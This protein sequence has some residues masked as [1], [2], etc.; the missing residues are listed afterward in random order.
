[1]ESKEQDLIIVGATG[2][3]GDKVCLQIAKYPPVTDL[4]WTIAGRNQEYILSNRKLSLLLAQIKKVGGSIPQVAII[5]V[6]ND[7]IAQELSKFK[8]CISCV[9]PF[10]FFGRPI[11]EACI[12]AKTDYVD[13]CGE[14]EFIEGMYADFNE[15]ATENGV[16]LILS[17]GY[18]SIPSDLG[19]LYSKKKFQEIGGVC[20]NVEFYANIKAGKSGLGINATT[21]YA[22]IHSF[23]K[24]KI[25]NLAS[26]P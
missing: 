20:A 14:T 23:D 16:S 22:A 11:F 4:K 5:D 1:M 19:V 2:F 13:I 8:V 12:K 3:T 6:E 15:I 24:F 17:C 7:N 10:R 9:G 25:L 26:R 18:D 21:F